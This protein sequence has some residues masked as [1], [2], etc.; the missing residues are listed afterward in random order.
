[1]I[2]SLSQKEKGFTLIEM[3]VSLGVFS[4]VITIAVGALLVIISTNKQLQAEQNVMSNLAF[5]MDSMTREIRTGYSYYCESRPNDNAGPKKIFKESGS[6]YTDHDN[7][8]TTTV[9]DCPGGRIDVNH[10]LQGVSFMESGD[11]I[12]QISANRILYYY[13]KN[14]SGLPNEGKIMRRVG[15]NV[16]QSI[17]PSNLVITEA[18]FY[19]TG[20]DPQSVVST[21]VEQ[22]T[23]TV[24]IE[25]QEINNPTG[26]IY[27]LQ[28]TVT[29]RILD[30]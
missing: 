23:V 26:K 14:L 4:I 22:P 19:V 2:K 30:I 16:A 29:Q 15:N 7:L 3:I 10:K 6:G 13:V 25:A 9:Q 27:K 1:M 24:Y 21:D 12:T 17:I 8:G 20:S 5:A 18:Q 28:T 11:S